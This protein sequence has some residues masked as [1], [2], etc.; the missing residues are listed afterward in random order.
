MNVIDVLKK[1]GNIADGWLRYAVN[2]RTSI[3]D[4]N[5]THFCKK[6]PTAYKEGKYTGWCNKSKGGCGCHIGA[7]TAAKNSSCP[8]GFWAN[9]W[10]K[11]EL[12][13]E[14]L[15]ESKEK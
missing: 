14:F 12:F 11:P 13:E 5:E 1:G 7:K 2:I 8:K 15:K 10:N 3:M 9:N 4:Y 6:C